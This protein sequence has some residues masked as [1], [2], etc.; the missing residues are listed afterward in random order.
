MV[1]CQG[2]KGIGFVPS[3]VYRH[4]YHPTPAP[5][6]QPHDPGMV[7]DEAKP[8]MASVFMADMTICW[9]EAML[10]TAEIGAVTEFTAP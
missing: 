9:R 8:V 10:D 6:Q 3:H 5:H 4:I 2:G 7:Q 1:A